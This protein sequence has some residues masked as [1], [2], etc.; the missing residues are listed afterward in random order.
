L[1]APPVRVSCPAA[2]EDE[3]IPSVSAEPSK[4]KSSPARSD[5]PLTISWPAATLASLVVML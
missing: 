5:W 3:E 1:P 2:A 4:V